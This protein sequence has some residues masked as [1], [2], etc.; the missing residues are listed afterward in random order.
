M[1][2]RAAERAARWAGARTRERKTTT[3]DPALAT[4]IKD[5]FRKVTGFEAKVGRAGMH[6]PVD[7]EVQLEELAEA[8]ERI[9]EP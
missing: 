4:R 2:V 1:S 5:G 3:I 6:V 7:D 8:L 9:L